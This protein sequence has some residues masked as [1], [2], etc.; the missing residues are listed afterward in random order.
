MAFEALGH[1]CCVAPQSCV[2]LSTAVCFPTT[3]VGYS[4]F[5]P[6]T[7]A[8]MVNFQ[9]NRQRVQ[10]HFQ[11]IFLRLLA[12][13]SSSYIFGNAPHG[14]PPPRQTA[15]LRRNDVLLNQHSASYCTRVTAASYH[16]TLLP[17]S[18]LGYTQDTN[19]SC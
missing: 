9:Q 16:G 11:N 17:P 18:N 12:L 6:E 1:S 4:V 13:C 19:A 5:Y 10:N 2:S 8:G 3:C 7:L 14:A 15:S